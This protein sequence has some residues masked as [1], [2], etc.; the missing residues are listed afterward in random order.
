[1]ADSTLELKNNVSSDIKKVRK[2]ATTKRIRINYG[3]GFQGILERANGNRGSHRV[4]IR[5]SRARAI[6]LSLEVLQAAMPFLKTASSAITKSRTEGDS[7]ILGDDVVRIVPLL[8]FSKVGCPS[9]FVDPHALLNSLNYVSFDTV[10]DS[11]HAGEEH[12][13]DSS[14]STDAE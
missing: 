11:H 7:V 1:M 3:G 2:N 10:G 9:A 12:E 8:E 6:N 14:G 13:S 5:G 4:R